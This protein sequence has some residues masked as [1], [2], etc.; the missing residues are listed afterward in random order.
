[1]KVSIVRLLALLGLVLVAPLQAAPIGAPPTD[2]S[3]VVQVQFQRP[4]QPSSKPTYRPVLPPGPGEDVVLCCGTVTTK[5]QQ[6]QLQMLQ[7]Y[8]QKKVGQCQEKYLEFSR[9]EKGLE[10]G[11]PR[12][13]AR[14][15]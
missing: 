10:L 2:V 8:Q 11:R 12:C 1:M 15:P 9:Q 13:E 4:H 6:Q 7:R 5:E 14:W 3:P